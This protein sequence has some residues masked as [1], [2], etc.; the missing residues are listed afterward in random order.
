MAHGATQSTTDPQALQPASTEP[1]PLD[2]R[3]GLRGAGERF[4]ELALVGGELLLER[5][6]ARFGLTH[7]E[8]E[9][10]HSGPCRLRISAR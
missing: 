10:A 8:L 9:L 6:H 7:L 1:P 2:V 3:V 4:L 5:I